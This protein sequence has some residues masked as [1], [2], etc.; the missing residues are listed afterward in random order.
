MLIIFT[1]GG[2][3]TVFISVNYRIFK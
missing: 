2:R 1:P 3:N